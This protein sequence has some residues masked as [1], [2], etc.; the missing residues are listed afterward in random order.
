MEA[1][2][3]ERVE[4]EWVM[5]VTDKWGQRERGCYSVREQKSRHSG[6]WG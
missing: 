1:P 2:V 3:E 5:E 6:W 4:P